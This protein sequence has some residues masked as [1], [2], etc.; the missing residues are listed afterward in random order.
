MNPLSPLFRGPTLAL[1]IL[2]LLIAPPSSAWAQQAPPHPAAPN[3]SAAREEIT[4]EALL[5]AVVRDSSELRAASQRVLAASER[6]DRADSLPDPTI[7]LIYRNVGFSSLTLGDEMMSLLGVRVTQ[8]LPARG[9]RPQRRVVAERQIGVAQAQTESVRRR[10][11]QQVSTAYYEL[12]FVYESIN[13]VNETRA[14]LLNLEE[15]AEARYAVGEGIQQDVLKAQVEVSILL[16]RLVQLDQQRGSLEA[17]INRLLGRRAS[18]ALGRPAPRPLVLEEPPIDTLVSEATQSS[19]ILA[20]RQRRIEE[21]EASVE[22]VRA[23]RRPDLLLSGSYMNRGSLPG[24]WEMNV[25]FTLPI[26]KSGRQDL[27]IEENLEELNARRSDHIDAVRA[28]ELLVQDSYLRAD[29]AV[30]LS[31]LY[32]DAIIPQALLSLESAMAGYAVGSVDFLNLLD[33]V[34]TLLTYR[35]ELEREQTNFAMALVRIEEHLGR[36]LGATPLDVWRPVAA[37]E[38]S[39]VAGAASWLPGTAPED[40]LDTLKTGGQ[41]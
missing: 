29:R 39:V 30:R 27:E 7:A 2:T 3:P 18:A 8:A 28:V 6:P 11:I 22:L 20:A 40:I 23:D 34:V 32:R 14:L 5:D 9:K 31:G 37:R 26:R 12:L 16:N 38:T 19:A 21:Q 13:I 10:L 1:Y 35:L 4:L 36:S 15:T 24:I 41:R 17:L 33:N 25:G